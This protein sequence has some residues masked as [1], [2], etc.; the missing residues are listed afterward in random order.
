MHGRGCGCGRLVPKRSHQ[1]KQYSYY[2]PIKAMSTAPILV[3]LVLLQHDCIVYVWY[4]HHHHHH[5]HQPQQQTKRSR[6]RNNNAA[7]VFVFVGLVLYRVL[8]CYSYHHLH[9]CNVLCCVVLY[10]VLSSFLPS[11]PSLYFHHRHCSMFNCGTVRSSL[12]YYY[13]NGYHRYERQRRGAALIQ[14]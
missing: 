4:H 14:Q 10:S 9:V 6:R 12:S 8:I 2:Y 11:F 7:Y 1:Y 3:V 13:Y 5:R